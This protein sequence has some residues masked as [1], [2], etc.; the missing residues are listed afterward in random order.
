MFGSIENTLETKLY[1]QQEIDKMI[2][3]LI[4]KI[5]KSKEQYSYVVGICNGGINIS[6]PL[7]DALKLPHKSVTISCYEGMKKLDDIKIDEGDFDWEPNGLIVD[8]L[9]DTGATITAF[10]RYFGEGHVAVLFW[11]KDAK[12]YVRRPEFYVEEKPNKWVVFPWEMSE[13]K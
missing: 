7:A 5:K 8:D 6:K 13:C 12:Y 4:R 2:R 1:S 3:V 11:R 9:I 10:K